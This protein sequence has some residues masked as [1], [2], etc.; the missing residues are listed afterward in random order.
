MMASGKLAVFTIV[1][2]VGY[3]VIYVICTE[4][5]LPLLTYHPVIGEVDFLWTPSL[6]RILRS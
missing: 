5:N 4:M 6:S 2:G 3:A 1:F